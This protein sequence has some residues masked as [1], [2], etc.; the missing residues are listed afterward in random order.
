MQTDVQPD[1]DTA[2]SAFIAEIRRGLIDGL[3]TRP[4][5]TDERRNAYARALDFCVRAYRPRDVLELTA[6]EQCLTF[7]YALGDVAYDMLHE[8]DGVLRSKMCPKLNATG[9]INLSCRREFERLRR[10]APA[11]LVLPFKPPQ[12]AGTARADTPAHA[13]ARRSAAATPAAAPAATPA[14]T[15]AVAP[16]TTPAEQH[17]GPGFTLSQDDLMEAARHFAA[18]FESAS[19]EGTAPVPDAPIVAPSPEPSSPP[20][21]MNRQQRRLAERA[22]RKA[23]RRAERTV[24]RAPA[25]RGTG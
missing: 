11:D 8:P 18:R 12:A 14:A 16:A 21:P 19:A 23:E 5:V 22:A 10:R 9:R 6:A 13:Q 3:A 4:D 1:A 17:A 20:Q 2:A 25:A 24:P 15:P 7:D